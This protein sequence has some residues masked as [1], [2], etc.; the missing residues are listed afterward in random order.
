MKIVELLNDF[1]IP[2]QTEGKNCGPGWISMQCPFCGDSSD[3]LGYSLNAGFFKCW[4]C[5]WHP[6]GLTISKLTGVRLLDTQDIIRQY[7]GTN[8]AGPV[9]KP[10]IKKFKWPSDSG[11]MNVRHMEYLRR[12]GFDPL[13]LQDQWALSGTGPA[14]QLDGRDYKHRILAPIIWEGKVVSFQSRDI[15]GKAELRY[16]TCP[17]DR[18]CIH[19]KHLVYGKPNH[20]TD[21]GICVEGITDV[22]R[23]GPRAFAT[24]GISFTTEQVKQIAKNF[25][26]VFILFDVEPQAQKQ[27]EK[28]EG[29]LLLHGV[30]AMIMTAALGEK[31]DPASLTQEEADYLVKNL[32]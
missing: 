5:G 14:S 7:G 26:R 29:E 32:K 21:A 6:T 20:W 23:L 22:W 9:I 4:R 11:P 27:A 3:H 2:F 16:K 15:T 10:E 1:N 30:G 24:F 8:I 12:R 13:K 31:P 19:H 25:K 17:K 18:E 28:L